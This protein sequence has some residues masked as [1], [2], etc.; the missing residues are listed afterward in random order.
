MQNRKLLLT[1]SLLKPHA[2][3]LVGGETVSL[4]L[5]QDRWTASRLE[6]IPTCRVAEQVL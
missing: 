4:S 5:L 1:R 3:V 2:F 6:S